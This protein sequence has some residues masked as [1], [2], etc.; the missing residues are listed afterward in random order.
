MGK[1]KLTTF[2]EA[3]DNITALQNLISEKTH[4]KFKFVFEVDYD[5]WMMNLTVPRS[6]SLVVKNKKGE[7]MEKKFSGAD[8]VDT[9]NSFFDF[10]QEEVKGIINADWNGFQ[11]HTQFFFS[12][13]SWVVE[14][15]QVGHYCYHDSLDD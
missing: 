7:N 1:F 13:N 5:D 9:V 3:M 8:F 12:K 2:D 6:F 4:Y 11:F 10:F 15:S 14:N